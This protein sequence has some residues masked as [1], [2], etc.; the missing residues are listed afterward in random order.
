[1]ADIQM[2][3][4]DVS[5]IFS[6]HKQFI[7]HH[8]HISDRRIKNSIVF[9]PHTLFLHLIWLLIPNRVKLLGFNSK[10][11]AIDGPHEGELIVLSHLADRHK[12]LDNLNL[13]VD[14]RVDR[15][16]GFLLHSGYITMIFVYANK[17]RIIRLWLI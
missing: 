10:N 12:L 3:L 17:L 16:C 1:M 8:L 9:N 15:H 11:L 7:A 13:I 4:D 14:I 5:T 6:A 2:Q